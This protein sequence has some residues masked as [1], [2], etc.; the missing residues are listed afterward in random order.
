MKIYISHSGSHDYKSE[1]YSPIKASKLSTEHDFFLPH[2]ANNIEVKAKDIIHSYELMVCEV[3][4]PSTGQGIEIGLAAAAN[5]PI[6]CF[7]KEGARPSSS[8]RFYSDQIIGYATTDD[9]MTKLAN[10]IQKT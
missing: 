2:E 6:V 8:L 1:L 3:S 4:H 10:I 5:V 9:L 7:Y